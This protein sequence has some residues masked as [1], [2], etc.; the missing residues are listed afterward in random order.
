M[1]LWDARL[2]RTTGRPRRNDMQTGRKAREASS[3][4]I[5]RRSAM[6]FIKWVKTPDGYKPVEITLEEVK[7]QNIVEKTKRQMLAR[8]REKMGQRNESMDIQK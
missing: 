2:T 4:L 5:F 6:P 3:S 8:L 1:T 7:A